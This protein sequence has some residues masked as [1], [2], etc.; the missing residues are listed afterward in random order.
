MFL[1]TESDNW[2]IFFSRHFNRLRC[3]GFSSG[4]SLFVPSIDFA[5]NDTRR[6]HIDYSIFSSLLSL[7]LHVCAYLIVGIHDPS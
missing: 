3:S 7:S 2:L 5:L 1:F 4:D 6:S